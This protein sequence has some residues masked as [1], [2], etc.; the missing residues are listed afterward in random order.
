MGK[1]PRKQTKSETHR[2][3][4][5]SFTT[6]KLNDF[7]LLPAPH[8]SRANGQLLYLNLNNPRY[9]PSSEFRNQ[10][11]C[12]V[13]Y[14]VCLFSS[15]NCVPIYIF[16]T[17]IFPGGSDGKVSASNAGDLGLIPG[18]GR[19]CGEG[20]GTHSSILA[21]KM[22]RGAWWVTVHG[23]A[24]G[25]TRPSTCTECSINTAHASLSKL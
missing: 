6:F 2:L 10:S 22:A 11:F 3:K 24:K 17:L 19:S 16:L 12:T 8:W 4:T 18:L 23:V 13:Y 25:W 14:K 5:N 7:I 21:W 9:L 15:V 20:N 1:L